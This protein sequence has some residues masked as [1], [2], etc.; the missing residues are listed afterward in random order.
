MIRHMKRTLL[1]L[2]AFWACGLAHGDATVD[3]S[4][5]SF[6]ANTPQKLA[7]ETL[8]S[9]LSVTVQKGARCT[10]VYSDTGTRFSLMP[11]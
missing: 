1:G 10:L 4:K 5:A 8:D 3:R 6:K 2:L 7:G 9:D 11:F